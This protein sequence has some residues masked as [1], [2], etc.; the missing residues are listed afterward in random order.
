MRY[1]FI[2]EL[3][4][5]IFMIVIGLLMMLGVWEICFGRYQESTAISVLAIAVMVFKNRSEQK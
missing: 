2:D 4:S 3:L 1:K 5:I